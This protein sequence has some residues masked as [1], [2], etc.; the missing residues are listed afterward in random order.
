[1]VAWCGAK[2]KGHLSPPVE[3]AELSLLPRA[4]GS[5]GWDHRDFLLP[6]AGLAVV[7]AGGCGGVTR[8]DNYQLASP[9]GRI[10]VTVYEQDDG[11]ARYTISI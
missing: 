5:M 4:A 6:G 2:R 1:M 9:N 7:A 10:V 8:G 3:L 11:P